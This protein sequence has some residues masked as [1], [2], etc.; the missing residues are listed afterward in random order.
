MLKV[1]MRLDGSPTIVR[2]YYTVNIYS[3]M[4]LGFKPVVMNW[5][6]APFCQIAWE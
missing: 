3:A 6:G 4:R 1:T 5:D 2:Q